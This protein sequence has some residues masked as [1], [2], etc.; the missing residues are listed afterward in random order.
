M[1]PRTLARTLILTLMAGAALS[2]CN[3]PTN[4]VP[5]TVTSAVA[6]PAPKPEFSV[7]EMMVMI[8]DQPGELLWDVEKPG[9]APKSDEDWYQL[10]THAMEVATAGT[11]LQLG[12]TG[13]ADADWAAKPGWQAA[14]QALTRAGQTARA[15]AQKKDLPAVISANGQIVEAC[16]ACHKEFKPDLPTSGLFMHQRPAAKT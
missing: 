4:T 13:P 15:A 11:L 8:V 7:N 5:P 16:E 12:G 14:S 6:A 3:K 10:E 1:P 2:A 9:K